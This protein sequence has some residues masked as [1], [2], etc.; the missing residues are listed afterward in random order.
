LKGH[1]KKIFEFAAIT[2]DARAMG[3][4]N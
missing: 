2:K 3:R 4:E 1:A